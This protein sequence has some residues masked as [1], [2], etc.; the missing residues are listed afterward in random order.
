M[1]RIFMKSSIG[2]Y[3]RGYE[4]VEPYPHSPIRLDDVLMKQIYLHDMK[5][6]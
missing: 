6:S 2:V 4:C 1:K 3:A 5:L